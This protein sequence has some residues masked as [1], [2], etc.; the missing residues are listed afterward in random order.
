MR[1][2]YVC[3]F[4]YITSLPTEVVCVDIGERIGLATWTYFYESGMQI[5][6]FPA[7]DSEEM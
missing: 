4:S 5:A 6:V 3:L 1:Y 7:S 2:H